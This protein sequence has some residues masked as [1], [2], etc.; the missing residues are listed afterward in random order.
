M[1]NK[2]NPLKTEKGEFRVALNLTAL[3]DRSWELLTLSQELGLE[4]PRFESYVDSTGFVEVWAIVLH[5]FHRFDADPRHVVDP[6]DEQLE[7]LWQACGADAHL[8]MMI[9]SNL[10]DCHLAAAS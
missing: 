2:F 5:S 3:E 9:S 6:W 7:A 10:E 8:K 4:S 1:K